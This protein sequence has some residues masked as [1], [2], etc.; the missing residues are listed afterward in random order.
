MFFAGEVLEEGKLGAGLAKVHLGLEVDALADDNV[1]LKTGLS[2]ID[3][4]VTAGVSAA[5]DQNAFA[6]QV[7]DVLVLAGVD[8]STRKLFRNSW[9]LGIPKM[10]IGDQDTIEVLFFTCCQAYLPTFA[11]CWAICWKWCDR[12]HRRVV[13]DVVMELEVIREAVDVVHNL[14]AAWK[15]RVGSRHGKIRKVR[16]VA[17]SDQM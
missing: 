3:C 1:H 10:P 6:F 5:D 4:H 13:L 12:F 9:N 16:L 2:N 15:V 14:R 17:R 11:S 7:T 8:L